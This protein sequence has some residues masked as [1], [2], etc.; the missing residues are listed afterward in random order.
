MSFSGFSLVYRI[1]VKK[2]PSERTNQLPPSHIWSARR[3]LKKRRRVFIRFKKFLTTYVHRF[4]HS[5]FGEPMPAIPRIFTIAKA[6]ILKPTAGCHMPNYAVPNLNPVYVVQLSLL[7]CLIV[8]L[9]LAF[10]ALSLSFTLFLGLHFRP[11]YP[12]GTCKH[13][14]SIFGRKRRWRTAPK[15]K[16]R[17]KRN[18]SSQR[19]F[20]GQSTEN[21]DKQGL[22]ACVK[23]AI[24]NVSDY[25]NYWIWA[26]RKLNS[27][28]YANSRRAISRRNRCWHCRKQ[29]LRYTYQSSS[30]PQ[31]QGSDGSPNTGNCTPEGYRKFNL[32]Q[33]FESYV[34]YVTRN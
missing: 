26:R 6:T 23:G 3:D 19:I 31:K 16:L 22:S 25:F 9:F 10:I 30:G 29:Y 18:R 1:S 5:D 24:S 7:T 28:G 32:D 34:K 11:L 13:A 15:L 8:G 2:K 4:I 17:N 27:R 33:W 12:C 21:P 20:M 14:R